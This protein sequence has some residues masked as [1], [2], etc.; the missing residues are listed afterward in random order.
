MAHDTYAAFLAYTRAWRLQLQHNKIDLDHGAKLFGMCTDY[1]LDLLC[2]GAG[3][4]AKRKHLMVTVQDAKDV[5]LHHTKLDMA[6]V[7][8]KIEMYV[9]DMNYL[10]NRRYDRPTR[11]LWAMYLRNAP[12]QTSITAGRFYQNYMLEMVVRVWKLAQELEVQMDDANSVK[13]F[14]TESVIQK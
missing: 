5:V 10:R 8:F 3:V 4:A 14:M 7:A 2:A 6:K 9:Q 12:V 13:A 1:M 11:R